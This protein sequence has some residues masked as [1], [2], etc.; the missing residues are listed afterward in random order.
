MI[1]LHYLSCVLRFYEGTKTAILLILCSFLEEKILKI[2]FFIG[3]DRLAKEV[4][5]VKLDYKLYYYSKF[6]K[7]N[8]SFVSLKTF[9]NLNPWLVSSTPNL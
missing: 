7:Y 9:I 1:A 8:S 2:Q 6:Y 3:R 5:H 4:N